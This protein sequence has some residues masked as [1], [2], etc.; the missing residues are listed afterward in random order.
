MRSKTTQLRAYSL[1]ALVWLLFTPTSSFAEKVNILVVAIH[2]VEIAK[3]SGS[4][5]LNI[6]RHPCHNTSFI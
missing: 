1:L 6:F 3:R 2:G 4:R 5:Q